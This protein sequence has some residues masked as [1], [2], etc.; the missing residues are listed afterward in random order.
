M[1]KIVLLARL[2]RLQ[3]MNNLLLWEARRSF[4]SSNDQEVQFQLQDEIEQREKIEKELGKILNTMER[5]LVLP[6]RLA[7]KS[8]AQVVKAE[9]LFRKRFS[10]SEASVLER[11]N[12]RLYYKLLYNH[13]LPHSLTR[14]LL[15]QKKILE[16]RF[17]E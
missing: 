3:V 8:L 4:F 1:K 6:Q 16:N 13:R 7:A 10:V 5:T 14:Q 2:Q 12:V 17:Q 9:A 11:M 15:K